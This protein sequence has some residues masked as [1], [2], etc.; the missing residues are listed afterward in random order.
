[1]STKILKQY[2]NKDL[3]QAKE[4]IDQHDKTGVLPDGIV[5]KTREALKGSNPAASSDWDIGFMV[6]RIAI[7]QEIAQRWYEE[8][9]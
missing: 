9:L 4:E 8:G 5:R 1:M 6:T 3:R 2:S 7:L